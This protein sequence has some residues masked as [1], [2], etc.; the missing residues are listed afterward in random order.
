MLTKRLIEFVKSNPNQTD[1]ETF[2]EINVKR[3]ELI[4]NLVR[5][6][7]TKLEAFSQKY[8]NIE[9]RTYATDELGN[10]YAKLNIPFPS[11]V[12][13][14]NEHLII[15]ILIGDNSKYELAYVTP[16]ALKFAGARYNSKTIYY[17]LV[18]NK[19][20]IKIPPTLRFLATADYATVICILE[21]PSQYF[22]YAT[23]KEFDIRFDEYPF[24]NEMLSVLKQQNANV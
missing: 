4:R 23:N 15:D 17:T 3:L 20:R 19:I 18:D 13:F 5:K 11:I 14:N 7:S 24:P 22:D 10:I 2:Y 21:D 16:L 6:S 1:T 8:S 12:M 9:L